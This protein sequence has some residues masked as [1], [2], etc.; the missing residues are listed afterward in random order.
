MKT[1]VW[2][3]QLP[4]WKERSVHLPLASHGHLCSSG[5]AT[6]APGDLRVDSP[7]PQCSHFPA[8]RGE[9][10]GFSWDKR[11]WKSPRTSVG[12]V[13]HQP[14]AFLFSSQESQTSVCG[15]VTRGDIFTG[16]VLCEDISSD[17]TEE[18]R[19]SQ[20]RE[21]SIKGRGQDTRCEPFLS[22]LSHAT[23]HH[24]DPQTILVV[25]QNDFAQ[26]CTLMTIW[27][28]ETLIYSFPAQFPSNKAPVLLTG[29]VLSGHSLHQAEQKDKHPQHS[30]GKRKA[31]W[32]PR[33]GL[34]LNPTRGR[35][36]APPACPEPEKP[37]A[38]S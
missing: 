4:K 33:W 35:Q 5:S 38:T 2:D 7:L 6:S 25:V 22:H 14:C 16:I 36:R 37:S 9:D 24:L 11:E 29:G 12:T 18:L 20:G 21:A 34:P 1:R 30:L 28:M 26:C 17:W 27:T 23:N 32:P 19:G 13:S 15:K 3:T 10:P 31:A 8:C